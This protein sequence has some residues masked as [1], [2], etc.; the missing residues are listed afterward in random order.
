M[1]VCTGRGAVATHGP[2]PAA[3]QPLPDQLSITALSTVT[4]RLMAFALPLLAIGAAVDA[5]QNGWGLLNWLGRSLRLPF[6]KL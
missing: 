1:S 6:D 3:Q 2:H 4:L 5:G